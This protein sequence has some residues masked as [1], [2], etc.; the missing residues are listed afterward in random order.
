MLPTRRVA[1]GAR[2]LTCRAASFSSASA[3]GS[4]DGGGP[5]PRRPLTP[6]AQAALD[7]REELAAR[8]ANAEANEHIAAPGVDLDSAIDIMSDR[9]IRSAQ[10]AGEFDHVRRPGERLDERRLVGDIEG[11]AGVVAPWVQQQQEIERRT[12]ALR[13]AGAASERDPG[14][15]ELNEAIRA[16]NRTC[17]PPFQR[18]LA[19]PAS[20]AKR[21]GR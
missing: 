2:R 18:P 12:E 20:L 13:A 15:L 21:D 19:T 14:L 7:A 4:S 11:T 1:A 10:A 5:P 6:L 8:V 9:A 17:P 3:S 16:F